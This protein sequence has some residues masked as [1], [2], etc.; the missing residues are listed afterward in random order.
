MQEYQCRLGLTA[1]KLQSAGIIARAIFILIAFK[2]GSK[3]PWRRSPSAT[4]RG[5]PRAKPARAP[6][7]WRAAQM[8][9]RWIENAK[10]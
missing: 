2:I 9:C 10:K 8:V 5:A 4:G 7:I 6:G 1:E 3:A